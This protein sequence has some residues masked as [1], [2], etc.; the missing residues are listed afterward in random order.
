V[1]RV[2]EVPVPE[3]VPP[4]AVQ[5]ATVTGTPSGLVQFA[6]RFTV[7]PAGRLVGLAESETV[8]GFFGGK[9][10]TVKLAVQLASLFFFSR[11]SVT[12]AVIV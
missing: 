8:G 12:R 1:L 11:A 3:T 6:D 2:A 9:G 4:L 7:P 5:D 10:F